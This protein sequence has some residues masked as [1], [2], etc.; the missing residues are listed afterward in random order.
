[1]TMRTLTIVAVAL[2]AWTCGGTARAEQ[3]TGD[4]WV[5]W[6][7]EDAVQTNLDEN[8]AFAPR[9][10]HEKKVISGGTWIGD[11]SEQYVPGKFAEY[12][13]EVPE[14]GEYSFFVRK[15]GSHANL[16]WRVDGGDWHELHH[17]ER[18]VDSVVMR[19]FQS[20]SWYLAG[21]VELEAGR[22]QLRIETMESRNGYIALDAFL[23]SAIPYLPRGDLKP[24]QKYGT[25]PEGWFAFEPD[26]DR[27]R[28][29]AMLDLSGMAAEDIDRLGRIVRSGETF[30]YE[31]GGEVVRLWSVNSGMAIPQM[32]RP[33]MDSLVKFLAKR[34]INCVRLHGLWAYGSGP[35]ATDVDPR[36]VDNAFYFIAK[37]KE[38]GIY[39]SI[40]PYFQHW[41]NLS[42]SKKFPG[43]EKVKN[44]RPFTLHFFHD[45]YQEVMKDWFRAILTRE[46]P[47]TGTRLA[48]DPVVVTF[49]LVN[50]DNFW[51]YTFNPERILPERYLRELESQFGDWLKA[52]YGTIEKAFD[53]WGPDGPKMKRDA[54]DEG[55]VALY[56]AWLLTEEARGRRNDKRARDQNEFLVH[57]QRSFYTEMSDFLEGEL[58][59]DGI[60][61]S[62]SFAVA[63]PKVMTGLVRLA[64][65]P[66]DVT[67]Y[68]GHYKGAMDTGTGWS[69]GEGTT[70]YDRS[71]LRLMDPKGNPQASLQSVM[72]RIHNNNRPT[73][74]TEFSYMLPNRYHGELPVTVAVFGRELGYDQVSFF[75]LST[76]AGWK[77]TVGN[78]FFDVLTPTVAG[79][80]PATAMLYRSGVLEEGRFLARETI[81]HESM[82][83]LEGTRIEPPMFIDDVGAA[84]MGTSVAE[85]NEASAGLQSQFGFDPRAFLIGKIGIDFLPDA[86][87]KLEV[88][89]KLNELIAGDER[90]MRSS[91]GQ[92]HWDI[93]RGLLRLEAPGGQGAAGF[94]GDAGV[95][96][97][98]DMTI[99]SDLPFG[100]FL[101]VA[102]D[103]KPLAE[104]E[105]ILLQ[106]MSE[107]KNNGY[108]AT[109]QTGK[110]TIQAMGNAPIV[111]R[112]LQGTVAFDIPGAADAKVTTLD[113]NGYPTGSFTG[114]ESI[115]LR[116]DVFYYIIER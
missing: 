95:I 5:W 64:Q 100:C 71:V 72:H 111:V 89:P 13:L 85:A 83:N 38:N 14:D 61:N 58:G 98:P 24:G 78:D 19:R 50:E 108:T 54:P 44:G 40:S 65:L 93:A 59:Y 52:R 11:D 92:Y 51:F 87:H 34:G 33:V 116:P 17:K 12:V 31:K 6:E 80:W 75:A 35:E 74:N 20:A 115:E 4:G 48:E 23:L 88:D 60:L 82:Y 7:A 73:V 112:N 67:D 32:P 62:T 81:D 16:R 36:K 55:R 15:L 101:A 2:L 104:S 107:A 90:G 103:E 114:A 37:L 76:V 28:D 21:Q 97:L 102:M 105:K 30:T 63:D 45:P 109:P 77:S 56:T 9:K 110:R 22:H 70:Y 25:A 41:V 8:F 69:A 39:V 10:P 42:Q 29:D 26:V 49:E 96:T 3:T 79:Q 18:A 99:E 66:L 53:A 91:T 106:V 47:Y 27:Y 94:L 46:N 113:P 43:Y 1:M 86:E 57:V 68:H 84:F